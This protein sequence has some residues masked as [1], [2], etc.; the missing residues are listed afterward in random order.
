MRRPDGPGFDTLSARGE[1]YPFAREGRQ[2]LLVEMLELAPPAT[3]EV[4]A[5]RCGM[6]RAMLH[7]AIGEHDVTGRRQREV[8]TARGDPVT[9]G[10]DSHNFLR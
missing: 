5:R 1:H 4:T 8:P 10:S 6:M 2:R 3:A 7:G 9:L